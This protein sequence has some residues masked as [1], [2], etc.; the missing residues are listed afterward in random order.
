MPKNYKGITT[1][2][3]CNMHEDEKP[4]KKR[5]RQTSY[6]CETCKVPVSVEECYDN[7]VNINLLKKNKAKFRFIR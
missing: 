6:W 4:S 1:R 7:H 3:N 5:A 2:L